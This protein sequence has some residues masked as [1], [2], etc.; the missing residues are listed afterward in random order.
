MNLNIMVGGEAGQGVQSIGFILAKAF[1]HGGY[2]IFADQDYESRVRGGHN[3][4]RVRVSD[5]ETGAIAEKVDILIAMNQESI[6]LHRGELAP[7]GIIIF[8]SQRATS[9]GKEE[10]LGIP[11]EKLAEETAGS[12]LMTNTVAL[13]A[14]LGLV[15]YER[16]TIGTVL[17]AHFGASGTGEANVKAAEAGYA[18]ALEHF[19][20]GA[21]VQLEPVTSDER[22]LIN[23]NE[24]LSLGA[25]AAGCTFVSS[26]PMTPASSIME[27]LAG[28][29]QEMGMVV[30]QPEDEIAAVNM[31][32]GAGYAGARSMTA[33]SGG[34]FCLMVEGLGLAGMTETPVVIVDAQRAG[35]AIGLPTRTEQGDLQFALHASHGDFPRAVL[36]PADVEDCFWLTVKAFNIAEKYQL[37]VII[38]TDQHLASSYATLPKFDLSQVKIERGELLS[39]TELATI[40]DYKRHKITPSGISPRALPGGSAL[41]ATDSDAHG[42]EGHIIEDAETRTLMMLKRMRKL[43]GLAREISP[44][45]VYGPPSAE[46]TLVGWG[47]TYGALRE[48]VDILRGEGMDVNHLH[49]TELWPFPAQAVTEVL[50]KSRQIFVAEI[51]AVGQMAELIRSQTGIKESGLI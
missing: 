33:T 45:R 19:P 16:E 51:N 49:L 27:Y 46:I 24:A 47:S 29:A 32:I 50:S 1:S 2:H 30:I 28:K 34:G 26:Y 23:G 44:P 39:A 11:M 4:Y 43:E 17:Q 42:E 9:T 10:S 13:G 48:T 6:D 8:D 38:L 22:M 41:V 7:D 36:A 12:K 14:A 21:S 18:Y 35:P 20:E 31:A 25:I 3:F 37:P 5:E 15:L 40:K